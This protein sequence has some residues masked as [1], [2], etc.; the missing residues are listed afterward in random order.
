MSQK[1]LDELLVILQQKEKL[2]HEILLVSR[3]LTS[4]TE[5]W[6][7]PEK[8]LHARQEYIFKIDEIDRQALV[9]RKKIT[10]ERKDIKK[11]YPQAWKQLENV[12]E[13]TKEMALQSEKLTRQGRDLAVERLKILEQ[14][15]N[16]L[17]SSKKVLT[18]YQ[19]KPAQF[20]GYFLDKKK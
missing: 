20:D 13:H 10:C 2:M 19:K 15:I 8:L 6:E 11:I 7:L 18:A 4:A 5:D 14:N 17:Q 1:I 12:W 9:L 16:K 3:G